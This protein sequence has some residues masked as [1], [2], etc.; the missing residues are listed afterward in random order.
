M[1]AKVYYYAD[2]SIST[3]D[4]FERELKRMNHATGCDDRMWFEEEYEEY[5]EMATRPD[6]TFDF[7]QF[8][9]Y[10]IENADFGISS[11]MN[12]DDE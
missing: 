11:S 1:D 12:A 6:G 8:E 3:R 4:I 5:I 2:R 9:R 7:D 10:M